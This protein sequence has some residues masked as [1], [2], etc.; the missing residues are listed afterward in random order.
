[1]NAFICFLCAKN[2]QVF[3]YDEAGDKYSLTP[4]RHC[5]VVCAFFIVGDTRPSSVT[6]GDYQGVNG[7]LLR[8]NRTIILQFWTKMSEDC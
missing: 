5:L 1:M 8:E 3:F 4:V 2:G 7:C 6:G